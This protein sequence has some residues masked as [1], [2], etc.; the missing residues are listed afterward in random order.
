MLADNHWTE[1]EVPDGG[2][3]EVT[4]GELRKFAAPW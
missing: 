4:E 1:R 2:D 3:G